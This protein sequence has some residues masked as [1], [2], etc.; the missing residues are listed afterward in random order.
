M[1]TLRTMMTA[2]TVMLRTVV[3]GLKPPMRRPMTA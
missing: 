1:I 3:G 2:R